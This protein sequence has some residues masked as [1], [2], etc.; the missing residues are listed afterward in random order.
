MQ[1]F[2]RLSLRGRVLTVG[3]LLSAA[4]VAIGASV[5]VPYVA[6]GPGVTYDTLGQ[7]Q[8]TEVISFTGT[9]IPST[10]QER[11]PNAGHLNMTTI[12]VADGLPL[13]AALGL[14]G[15]SDYAVVPREDFF[16]PDQSTE[17]VNQRNAELFAESQSAAEV[18]ALDYL[19]YPDVVYVGNITDNSPSLGKLRSQDRITQING[20]PVTDAASV[21]AA[22]AATRPGQKVTIAVQRAGLPV[23]AQITLGTNPA[24]PG[25]GFLGIGPQ[26]RPLAPFTVH[27]SLARIGG[28]S[29]GLMFTLGIIDKLTPGD[30]TGGRFIAGTGEIQPPTAPATS[31]TVGPIGGILMKMIG[32]R[33]K[34]A[35]VFL[36][37]AAN[38]AEAVTRIPQGLELV[39]V[40]T[41]D[42]AMT[43]LKDLQAGK[44]PAGC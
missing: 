32:A 30:L 40:G 17:Q 34:G 43:A 14:W 2:T 7:V 11:F 16:P 25:R 31:P 18:A 36:V 5:P 35:T 38:C 15:S 12:S 37:P 23:T 41:L 33:D 9:G 4:L 13:F 6:L 21:Q 28:P 19:H 1:W 44:T 26:Q 29:A 10:V 8:G 42:E 22:M 24:R 27:I 39:K 20:Q 3:A